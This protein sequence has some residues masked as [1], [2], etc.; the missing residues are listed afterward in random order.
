MNR[1]A[2]TEP[3]SI[4]ATASTMPMLPARSPVRSTAAGLR[5]SPKSWLIAWLTSCAAM[6]PSASCPA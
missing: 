6:M 1:K 5:A 4:S 3:T 2:T